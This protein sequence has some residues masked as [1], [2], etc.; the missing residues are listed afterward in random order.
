M[1]DSMSGTTAVAVLV[2]G[3][4]LH[5]ARDVRGGAGR[6]LRGR[7]QDVRGGA[8]YGPRGTAR[9]AFRSRGWLGWRGI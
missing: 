1:D 7:A 5:R 4:A 3:G 6:G 2:A 8:G 9:D